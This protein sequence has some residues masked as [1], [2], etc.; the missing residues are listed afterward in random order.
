[1]T[2]LYDVNLLLALMDGLHV[3]HTIAHDWLKRTNVTRWATCPTTQNGFIRVISNR[4]YTNPVSTPA[5]AAAMLSA[6]CSGSAHEF[7]PD[8]V[9][10]IGGDPIHPDRILSSSQVS[11]TY[12][13]AMARENGGVLATFDRRLVADPVKDGK[14]HLHL[15]ESRPN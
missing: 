12:L 8:K 15:I 13:L 9:S 3:H 6:A 2:F 11:D 10:L 4:K 7:W 1:L 5:E 14:A